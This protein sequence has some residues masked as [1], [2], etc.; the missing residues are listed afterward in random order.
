[1]AKYPYFYLATN[2]TKHS[3]GLEEAYKMACREAARYLAAGINVLCP[4]AHAHGINEHTGRVLPQTH[5]FWVGFVDRP[6][7]ENC[8]GVI[9]VTS[10]GWEQS[11]GIQREI[12]WATEH[13]LPIYYVEPGFPITKDKF[14]H[15]N[16]ENED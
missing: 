1:M 15:Y 11:S 7:L 16:Y 13:E 6:M 9:V 2:Y 12:K 10:D 5:D 14:V 3:E 4:I 8:S